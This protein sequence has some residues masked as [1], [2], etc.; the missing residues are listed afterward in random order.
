MSFGNTVKK[1]RLA[2]N[3]TLRQFCVQFGHD[4][5]NWSKLERNINPPPKDEST[6][7]RWAADLGLEQAS[8]EWTEFMDEA[9]VARGNIPGDLMNDE[10]LVAKLP[11]FFRTVR[12]AE[13]DDDRLNDLIETIRKSHSP[14]EH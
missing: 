13:L 12:G 9:A 7:V 10:K 4:P 1:L 6:L 5:S 14:D 2:R 8:A 11:A 3:Q